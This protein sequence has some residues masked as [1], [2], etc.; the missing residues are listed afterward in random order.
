LPSTF[1]NDYLGGL[2]APASDEM[3]LL[4]SANTT[5]QGGKTSVQI[6]RLEMGRVPVALHVDLR[7]R[8]ATHP[9]TGQLWASVNERDELGGNLVPDL[10]TQVKEGGFYVWP[11]YYLGPNPDPRHPGK[12]P[13]LKDKVIVPDVLL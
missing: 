1:H 13:E 10:I 2:T 3:I 4:H 12:R 7:Q 8:L 6:K 5:V 11:W 9:K